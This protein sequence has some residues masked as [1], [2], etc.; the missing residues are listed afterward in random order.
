MKFHT[1]EWDK[2]NLEVLCYR[3]GPV[4]FEFLQM[5][6]VTGKSFGPVEVAESVKLPE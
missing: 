3:P 4:D 1:Q 2:S 6:D 5:A